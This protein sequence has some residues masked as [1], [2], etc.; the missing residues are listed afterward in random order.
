MDGRRRVR[1]AT[2]AGPEDFLEALFSANVTQ[3]LCPIISSS[4][5]VTDLEIE[6]GIMGNVS[7]ALHAFKMPLLS[8]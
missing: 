8:L 5:K 4:V 6:L 2:N 3:S 7:Q 1:G